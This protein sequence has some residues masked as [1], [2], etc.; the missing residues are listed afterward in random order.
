M[1]HNSADYTLWRRRLLSNYPHLLSPGRIGRLEVRNRLVMPPMATNYGGENGEVTERMVRYYAERAKGGTGLIIV[2]NAQIDYPGGKNV[3]LQHRIDDDKF[4]PGLRWLAESI[5]DHGAL[6]FQQIHHAGRQTS[7]GVTEGAPV[8]SSSPIPCG[9]MQIQPEELSREQ[10]EVLIE[11]FADAATRAKLAGF[12]GI[13]LHGA[14]GYL[15][16]QF[17]SPWTNKRVDQWGGTFERRMRFPLEIIRRCRQRV[18]DRFAI[19]FRMSA[20]EF[21]E[22][23]IHQEEGIRIAQTLEKAGIDILHVST[24]IYESMTAVLEP[25]SYGEGW[26]VYLAEA[27]KKAI[28]IPVITVGVIRTPEMADQIIAEGKADFV[29]IGRG[30]ITDP[31]FAVKAAKGQSQNINKCIVC[32]IGC[33]GDGIFASNFM[34]CTV[35]PA[36]GRE[37][38]YANIYPAP[39]R[40]NVVVVGGGP[41][42]MEAA[43]VA[44]IRGHHVMVLEKNEELG[45]QMLIAARP[46]HKDKIY[47]FKDFLHSELQRLN[48]TIQLG[49]EASADTVLQQN[50]DAVIIATGARPSET[51]LSC[52]EHHCVVQAWDVLMDRAHLNAQRVTIV[53]GGEVGLE[54]AEFLAHRGI[55]SIVLEMGPDVGMDMEGI[56]RIDLLARLA[57]MDIQLHTGI[58]ITQITPDAVHGWNT[59]RQEVHFPGDAVILALG[60]TPINELA[61]ELKGRVPEVYLIGDA[62]TPRRIME[63]AYEGMTSAISIGDLEKHYS[64]LM[65]F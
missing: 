36:V 4:I 10:I 59:H 57:K 22:G 42:G 43:R 25:M 50:P 32:N 39:E 52:N 7:L 16:N 26:R 6:A 35:N 47:W 58:L 56:T 15:I 29:A 62:R 41:A 53:G 45:G 2:E 24:G 11:K 8:V 1:W 17:M 46:P 60:S 31:E 18:G 12:D 48:V 14:H 37:A 19:G 34:R 49:V 33:V 20:D 40:K 13:E 61:T 64:P 23:G 63:A 3:V 65:P 55:A 54:T 9:F 51:G 27:I 21:I 28:S 5:H 44:A 38:D 30:L